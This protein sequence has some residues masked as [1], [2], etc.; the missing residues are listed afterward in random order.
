MTN[1]FLQSAFCCSSLERLRSFIL[2]LGCSWLVAPAPSV[3]VVHNSAVWPAAWRGQL[4][5]GH[6]ALTWLHARLRRQ[7]AG[8]RLA[9]TSSYSAHKPLCA[10]QLLAA[11]CLTAA[12]WPQHKHRRASWICPPAAVAPVDTQGRNW[13]A[14]LL[15]PA[16]SRDA[17]LHAALSNFH[18]SGAARG[19][20]NC[21]LQRQP[22]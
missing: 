16:T 19:M 2:L 14:A 8:V 7:F 22:H 18:L 5:E 6:A 3:K 15:M 11:A 1:C 20:Y 10:L 12:A 4:M 9:P 21:S 13:K 17:M